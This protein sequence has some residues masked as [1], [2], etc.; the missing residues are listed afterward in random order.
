MSY[1]KVW[2]I[3]ENGRIVIYKGSKSIFIPEKLRY[4]DNRGAHSE[5][6][7]KSGGFTFMNVKITDMQ[8]F[9]QK[10]EDCSGDIYIVYP[11]G[12]T[13]NIH[14]NPVRQAELIDEWRANGQCLNLTLDISKR[15]DTQKLSSF[16]VSG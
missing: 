3:R 16:T 14:N 8:K 5:I 1:G 4:N 15:V 2:G 10:V 11:G 7:I 13:E 6:I 12:G 9:L